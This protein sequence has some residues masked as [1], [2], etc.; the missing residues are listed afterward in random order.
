MADKPKRR[1]FQFRLRTLLIAVV[2]I[3]SVCAYVAHEYQIVAARR[4]WLKE[5]PLAGERIAFKVDRSSVPAVPF[6]RRLLGDEPVP[7]LFVPHRAEYES[8]KKLFPEAYLKV[9]PD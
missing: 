6:V 5:H 2:L 4:E 1:W 9:A 8:T 7:Y 3:G